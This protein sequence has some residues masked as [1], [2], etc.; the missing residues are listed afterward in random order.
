M[1]FNSKKIPD[2]RGETILLFRQD[3]CGEF[4]EFENNDKSFL[5]FFLFIVKQYYLS[6]IRT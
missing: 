6:Y 2:I 5:F 1:T 4:I 3:N